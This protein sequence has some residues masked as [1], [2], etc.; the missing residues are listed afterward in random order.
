MLPVHRDMQT[1]PR[2][3]PPE[4]NGSKLPCGMMFLSG[5]RPYPPPFFTAGTLATF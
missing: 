2:D 4:Q 5:A 3:H 1:P